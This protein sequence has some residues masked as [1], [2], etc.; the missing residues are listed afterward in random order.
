MEGARL[1][2]N[3]SHLWV[4]A[5]AYGIGVGLFQGPPVTSE[6]NA[7]DTH[8]Q[9]LGLTTWCTKVELGRRYKELR[10]Q[11]HLFLVPGPED[12]LKAAYDI[13]SDD[14][15]RT[16]YDE[17]IGLAANRRSRLNLRLLGLFSKSLT[18]A[19]QN[20]T[21]WE[22][23][24]LVVIKT[25]EHFRSIVAATEVIIHTDH[26]NNTVL[27][28]A[29]T[30]PDKILRMLL[31]VEALISP[32]WMFT[33]GRGQIGDGLSRNPEDRDV[34]RQESEEKSHLPKTLS[35]AFV[36][37]AKCRL[38]GDLIDD[39][40]DATIP[41]IGTASSTCTDAS[42]HLAPPL[43]DALR[44]LN[45]NRIEVIQRP[46]KGNRYGHIFTFTCGRHE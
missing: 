22:R 29:L 3:P 41:V 5:C 45:I 31:T 7:V 34:V 2:T 18:L 9:T 33:R 26:L 14:A 32:R 15:S 23:E 8:Y 20:W 40:G 27:N 35:E 11:N 13:L 36:T 37:V 17:S 25:C 10:R 4:D 39:A 28:L 19:E 43:W 44:N 16:A 6:P 42:S 46:T 12:N 1:K 30:Q 21:T 24:L 38:N